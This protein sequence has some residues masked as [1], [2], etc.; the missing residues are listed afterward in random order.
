MKDPQAPTGYTIYQL[1]TIKNERMHVAISAPM[2]S[3]IEALITSYGNLQAI[4]I[5]QT[6][7]GIF[8]EDH[9]SK[10]IAGKQESDITVNQLREL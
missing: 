9:K 3:Q 8:L 7:R 1:I 10:S 5:D 2:Q 4:P 6:V